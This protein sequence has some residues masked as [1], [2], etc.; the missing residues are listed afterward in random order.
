MLQAAAPKP[1]IY[2][3]A[4]RKIQNFPEASW[5]TW[6]HRLQSTM[7]Q[8]KSIVCFAFNGGEPRTAYMEPMQCGLGNIMFKNV[9]PFSD[10]PMRFKI[11]NSNI[12]CF[13]NC[14][15]AAAVTIEAEELASLG[16]IHLHI[17]RANGVAAPCIHLPNPRFVIE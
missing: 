5:P 12:L 14:Q 6:F 11:L 1:T 15:H 4:T 9:K 10:Y 8:A 3:N 17:T 16:L 13:R 2:K 7:S